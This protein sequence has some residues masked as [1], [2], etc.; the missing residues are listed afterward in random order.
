MKKKWIVLSL[1]LVVFLAAAIWG[2]YVG[3]HAYHLYQVR[4]EIKGMLQGGLDSVSPAYAFDLIHG[5]DQDLNVLEKNLKFFYPVLDLFGG[6]FAQVQPAIS[7]LDTLVNYA[8]LM[9]TKVSPMFSSGVNNQVEILQILNSIFEDREFV[10][11]VYAYSI[12]IP[13]KRNALDVSSL[14][15]RFQD[16]FLLIDKFLPINK[17]IW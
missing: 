12:V 15:L 5:V 13:E 3:K 10:H 4:Q 8:L 14:P 6:T 2:V 1:I 7:Y 9:E 11:E 17:I 16:D